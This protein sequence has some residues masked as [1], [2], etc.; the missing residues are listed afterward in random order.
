M[1]WFKTVFNSASSFF[2]KTFGH[3][4]EGFLSLIE[5]LSPI[6]LTA[7]PIVKK[8]ASLTPNKTDDAI[9]AAYE[10]MGFAGVFN[11]GSDKSLA[12]R[13]LAKR[14]VT[15]AHPDPVADY[16]INA[17]IELAYSKYKESSVKTN[18]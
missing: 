7:Y 17:A 16:L 4:G 1:N 10:S 15:A 18:E 11:K 13:D 12:L 9:L 14:A 5:K 3:E 8:I 2:G 6:V